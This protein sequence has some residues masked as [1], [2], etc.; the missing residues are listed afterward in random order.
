MQQGTELGVTT[1]LVP[2]AQA[3]SRAGR[4]QPAGRNL[5]GYGFV[6]LYVVLLV[7]FGA[8]P[9]V[10]ALYLSF[11][12]PGGK[13]AGLHNYFSTGHDFRFLPAFEHIAVYLLIWLVVLVVLVPFL[14][15]MLHGGI[16]RTVP[17]FRFVFYIPGAFVGSAGVLVWLL[18]LDPSV[19]PWHFV[20]S[21]FHLSSLYQ[22]VAP[23]HLPVIFVVIAFWTGAGSWVV[24]MNGAL[25]NISDE[26]T[27]AARVDGANAWQLALRV[28]LPLIKRWV[29]YMVILAFAAGTQ[30]F[31]EP[32]MLSTASGGF[33]SATWSPNQLAYYFAFSEDNFN[34]AA[35]I[36]VD[37]LV[38]GLMVAA[39]F[40]FGSR[41]FEIDSAAD[42]MSLVGAQPSRWRA[43]SR[44]PL[45]VAGGPPHRHPRL[46]PARRT[47]SRV[48]WLIVMLAFTAFFVVPVISVLLSSMAFGP[49]HAFMKTWDEIYA[50]QGH[51]LLTWLGNS[52]CYSIGGLALALG[53][54]VLAGYGLALTQFIGRRVLLSVTLIVMIMPASA[55]V[56]PLFLEMN[57]VH[58]LSTAWAVVLPFG[59]FPFGV[60]L[61]YIFFSSAMPK[62]LLAAARVDGASEWDVFCRIA[63][64]LARPIVALIGFFAFVSNWTN[65]FLPFVMLYDDKQYP[66]PVALEY[67]YSSVPRPELAMATLVAVTPVFIVFMF[68]QRALVAGANPRSLRPWGAR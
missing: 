12:T 2:T 30:L 59:F 26:V 64:P 49:S 32:Q 38:L 61:S 34:Y 58:L 22:T 45:V 1:S 41:L 43:A 27:D 21:W 9:T 10:Y 33:V 18:M 55:L 14:A 44:T 62:E 23:A 28:K 52:A 63:L 51:E 36:S 20:M 24:V 3:N 25:N 53:G 4:G 66:L 67:L 47:W 13:W 65:F 8:A 54:A 29:V 46:R 48:A 68:A 15:L 39:L 6:S 7:L 57:L 5:A 11:T 17:F 42:G 16:R 56:L 37:L 50:F 60:Y 19:S 35:A 31:V 40:A